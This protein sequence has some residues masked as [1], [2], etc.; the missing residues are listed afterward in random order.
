MF[1]CTRC[2]GLFSFGD[3]ASEGDRIPSYCKPCRNEMHRANRTLT[4]EHFRSYHRD[5]QKTDRL[6]NPDIVR[7]DDRERYERKKLTKPKQVQA[8]NIVHDDFR[9]PHGKITKQPC[10]VCGAVAQAHHDDYSKP[11]EVRWLCP[12]HHKQEHKECASLS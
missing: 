2:R 8:Q 4:P 1:T 7:A 11:L 6:L 12:V 5:Y 10:E 9:S 3:M